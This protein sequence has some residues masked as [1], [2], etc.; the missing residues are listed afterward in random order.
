MT[1]EILAQN[2]KEFLSQGGNLEEIHKSALEQ[3]ISEEMWKEAIEIITA[4]QTQVS[5]PPEEVPKKKKG[6]M[7]ILIILI[8][9]LSL[10]GFG[11]FGIQYLNKE[12][13]TEPV[14]IPKEEVIDQS[15]PEEKIES[16]IKSEE[17]IQSETTDDFYK[18][19]LLTETEI[20]EGFE[21]LKLEE[22]FTKFLKTNPGFIEK[23][24]TK[25]IVEASKYNSEYEI[26]I[27]GTIDLS[28]IEKIY[29]SYY[30]KKIDENTSQNFNIFIIKFSSKE[31]L[32]SEID[33][34]VE[35][36]EDESLSLSFFSSEDI[37]IGFS[38]NEKDTL[39]NK[40]LE[41][42]KNLK[43]IDFT[44]LMTEEELD[45]YKKAKIDQSRSDF[46]RVL[47][48]I[49]KYDLERK[50][51]FALSAN[52]WKELLEKED[53]K[54]PKP[55][56]NICYLMLS[57]DAYDIFD[58]KWAVLTWGESISNKNNEA[59]IISETKLSFSEKLSEKSLSEINFKKEDFL[60]SNKF[61]NAI[62][63]IDKLDISVKKRF[64]QV[65]EK[66]E[67][68]ELSIPNTEKINQTK[69]N[70]KIQRVKRKTEKKQPQ[71]KSNEKISKN[72]LAWEE[73][74]DTCKINEKNEVVCA[75]KANC[76]V[77]IEDTKCY[78]FKIE[79]GL[80]E[81]TANY[82]LSVKNFP[83]IENGEIKDYIKRNI[84]IEVYN[85]I[86][87]A[88]FDKETNTKPELQINVEKFNSN[89]DTQSYETTYKTIPHNSQEMKIPIFNNFD[90]KGN[91]LEFSDLFNSK[92]I[93]SK[94]NEIGNADLSQKGLDSKKFFNDFSDNF[95]L[96]KT[97]IHTIFFSFTGEYQ[98]IKIPLEK[99]KEY[100]V[101]Y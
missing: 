44:T 75:E 87:N 17:N 11:Y 23:N 76:S 53:V 29:A 36:S 95:L 60:C 99:I 8:S 15:A 9:F 39:I 27:L 78:K 7:K 40:L 88:S 65:N 100:L 49:L 28:K 83:E 90:N 67:I 86:L 20:P 34:I 98:I 4:Q 84:D 89:L 14:S 68:E 43:P 66:G 13:N 35:T 18:K 48:N 47:N 41:K 26:S 16:E 97:E 6:N 62:S 21:L 74:C 82:K 81:E 1:L 91:Q 63:L 79:A 10:I 93:I 30:E 61:K 52:E 69:S 42:D 31:I 80:M 50:K 24:K 38:G 22:P 37:L 5:T 57:V 72:C 54:I 2:I 94:I 70:K 56:N 77:Q 55:I 45:R 85:F 101:K 46:V 71:I 33:N 96:T 25:F 19:F 12:K 73:G 32:E 3:G 92:N 59:D 51:T 58:D 64:L